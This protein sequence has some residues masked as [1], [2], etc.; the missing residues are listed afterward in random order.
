MKNKRIH[1]CLLA[2]LLFAACTQPKYQLTDDGVILNL[3][4]ENKA[5]ASKLRLQVLGDELIHVSATP[6]GDFPK[7]S[8]LIVVPGLKTVPFAVDNEGDSIRLSTAKLNVMIS[9][10]DGGI[11]FKD[12]T[13]KLIL[14]EKKGGGRTFTPID[15]DG[16]KGYTIRQLFDSP[17]DEAFYGLG[18]HQSDEFN[19]K[20]KSEEL[21]QYN[22]K[23]SVPFVVS[24]K[25]YGLLWDSYSLSRFGDSREY[26][27]LNRVFNLYDKKGEGGSL[28]GT[29][30]RWTGDLKQLVR[31]EDSLCF[32]DIKTIKNLPENFPLKDANVTYEGEIEASESGTYRFI[33][34]YAGYIKVYINN[35]LVVPERWRTAWNPNS[36]K[37]TFNLEAG[38]RVP[39]RVEWK[40]NGGKSYC[41]LRVQT[42]QPEEEQNSQV[43][44]SEMNKKMDYYFV[45]GKSMDEIIKG[46]RTL[47]G[48]SQIMPKWAMGFWQSRERYK[49][50]NQI[51]ST[52]KEFR[53]L[54]F[55]IDNI[56]LDWFYWPETKWG[57][58]Q[59][60]KSRFLAPKAMVDSIH[61]MHAHMMI[62][63]WPKFYANTKH[64]KEFEK[65]GWMY[66]QAVKDSIR[67]WVGPGYVG[68]FYDA[69]SAGAR[70]LFWKQMYENLYP[71]GIDA[72][73]MDASEPNVLDCTDMEYRKALCGPTALGPSAEYFNAY[74][75]M[76]AEAIYN[77][78]RGVAPNKRVFLL[79][80][81]GFAGLQ[82]YS[83]ATWS[84]D[85]ATRWED[86]KAQIAAGINFSISGNPYWTMDIGGFCVE[87]RYVKGQKVY[88]RTGKVDADYK[89]WRELNTRWYQFGAFAPL[90]RAHGQYPYREPWNIAPKG[91]PT[92]NS[93]LYYTQL[94]YRLMP[95][96]Y[97]LAGMTWFDDYT[98]MR[99]LV[100]DFPGDKKVENVGDQYMFGPAFMV[101]PVYTYQARSRKVY[102]P[103][104]TDWYNFY[105]GKLIQGGQSL[106]VDAPYNR[107]PLFV[108]EGAI[109]P[110]GPEIQYTGEKPVDPIVLYVYRGKDGH[111]TLYED[112]GV[113][114]DYEK[115][116]YSNIPFSYND[117]DETLTIG[118]RKGQFKGM[119]KER[120]FVIVPVSKAA[121]KGFDPDAQGQQVHYDGHKLT[122]HV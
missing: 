42:P 105:T 92:Y 63:V 100:M 38:Q 51:L 120:T 53:T 122:I 115:G 91:T 12:K 97:T 113:N 31:A 30:Q 58:H 2:G 114:Y 109:I 79:T 119:L 28:T 29:Y 40:P 1:L 73:W 66:M 16:T 44:W 47:T 116:A 37:F 18:Q 68:S 90:Y 9:K 85:I 106:T 82:H 25:N 39:L 98:I 75:L 81:S 108:H 17:A 52:L 50:Q 49:T 22:T 89:E 59:F 84:G 80:R 107:M 43:W 88:N 45:Y 77:G 8:S 86:M 13:G 32:E 67:D 71:L 48:K 4:Q 111:F 69:Y 94:R 112:E 74:A 36:Y 56:V 117:A 78:Q 27:Q 60:D 76:N 96:I 10:A 61:A 26:K 3:R 103:K 95:Y 19:Y 93:I 70:K 35:E 15:V 57:S 118:E 6:D 5:E 21:F 20:G 55:P 64:F 121:P 87:D 34:Y 62:S 11:K 23:V 46:Y 7:D 83:T 104:G 14:A 72:W 110:V 24:N 54:N 41:G 33:L 99:P 65:H 102:F 101:C